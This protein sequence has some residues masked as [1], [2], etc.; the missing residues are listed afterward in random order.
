MQFLDVLFPIGRT[1]GAFVTSPTNEKQALN[2][3]DRYGVERALVFHTVSRDCDPDL[4]N[5]ELD[6]LRH[7]ER[8]LPIWGF[9]TAVPASPAPV[10][11]LKAALAAEVRA[12]LINPCMRDVQIQ[13]S[14][15]ALE[16]AALLEM[17]RLPLILAYRQWDRGSDV[18]DWY[19][20]AEF[21]RRFPALPVIA[22]Q[23]RAR[24]NRPMFDALAQASNLRVVLSAVWQAQMIECICETFG[25]ERLLFSLGLPGLHPTSF[26]AVVTYA[27]VTPK[28]K[29]AIAGGNL[30]R[31][32]TEANYEN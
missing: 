30:V 3:L 23:H 16:L 29:E 1:N 24:A 31:L 19:G 4:G 25:P 15:R 20:L 6:W 28:S 22:W 8:L 13:N 32:L 2:T 5:A 26:Q 9:E 7:K 21:C 14:V 27:D 12:I 11:F 10:E 18:I 17:R